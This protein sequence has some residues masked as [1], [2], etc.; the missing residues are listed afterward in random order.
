[1]RPSDYGVRPKSSP[2]KVTLFPFTIY[3]EGGRRV[4]PKTIYREDTLARPRPYR[5]PPFKKW[6]VRNQ[7]I[8][9]VEVIE[10]IEYVDNVVEDVDDVM[11]NIRDIVVDIEN[12]MKDTEGVMKDTDEMDFI[13]EDVYTMDDIED[14][15]DDMREVMYVDIKEKDVDQVEAPPEDVTVTVAIP[16]LEDVD[17]TS[18]SLPPF[19]DGE[20]GVEIPA[21][22]GG[23]GNFVEGL[24]FE[25]LVEP[26]DGMCPMRSN[27]ASCEIYLCRVIRNMLAVPFPHC[28]TGFE[29]QG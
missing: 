4:V 6:V 1:M 26:D 24:T 16:P 13:E 14:E 28:Y 20:V 27:L 10:S 23:P 22:F 21:N 25:V 18:Q 19:A 17:V 2:M 5:G 29:V 3:R 7:D 11:K 9:D 15:V 12:I 8:E